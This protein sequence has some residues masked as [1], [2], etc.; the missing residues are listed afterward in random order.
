MSA[1]E[2]VGAQLNTC[3]VRGEGEIMECETE[4]VETVKA[5]ISLAS[6][7]KLLNIIPLPEEIKD[8][9]EKTAGI[10][11]CMKLERALA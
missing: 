7:D 9:P 5:W 8:G 11:N 10:R 6:H 3:L 4:M 2:D 1:N